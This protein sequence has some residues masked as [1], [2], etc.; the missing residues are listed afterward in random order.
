LAKTRGFATDSEEFVGDIVAVAVGITS[1]SGYVGLC[2][3]MGSVAQMKEAGIERA[4]KLL[5]HVGE[6]ASTLLGDHSRESMWHEP[7]EPSFT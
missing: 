3:L 2:S 1:N 7:A 4:G 5:A 6:R